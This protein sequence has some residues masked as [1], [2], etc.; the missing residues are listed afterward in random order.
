MVWCRVVNITK[1]LLWRLIVQIVVNANKLDYLKL[2]QYKLFN[3]KNSQN[4][5]E[6]T[7][8]PM[9]FEKIVT[10]YCSAFWLC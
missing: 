1:I 10:S 6:H 4:M 2:Y 9:L 3:R 8:R 7:Y 5:D